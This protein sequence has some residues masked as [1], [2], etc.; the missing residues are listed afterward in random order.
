MFRKVLF[1]LVVLGYSL[2]S[3][4]IVETRNRTMFNALTKNN[5]VV[6]KFSAQW[7][8]PCRAIRPAYE[9]L[10]NISDYKKITFLEVDIDGLEALSDSYNIKSIPAFIFL[11]NG[12]QMGKTIYGPD[13]TTLKKHLNQLLAEKK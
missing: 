9:R 12:E 1:L 13:E 10:S 4:T 6:V 2:L 11:N 5:L 8:G 3:A 7:C